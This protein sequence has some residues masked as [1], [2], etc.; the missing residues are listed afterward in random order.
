M[1]DQN[2]GL[3]VTFRK[4]EKSSLGPAGPQWPTNEDGLEKV[5]MKKGIYQAVGGES[6]IRTHGTV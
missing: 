2:R 6:G 1:N 4:P 5:L 3:I